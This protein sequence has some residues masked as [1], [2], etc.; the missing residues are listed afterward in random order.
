MGKILLIERHRVLRQAI[1]FSLFPEHEVEVG[2]SIS[3]SK[4]G[5]LKDYD[6]LIVDG[7]SLRQRGQLT[8]EFAR[9]IQ[10][11]KIPTIWLEDE[12]P[13][14]PPKREKLLVVKK[15]IERE[16]FLS[17]LDSLLSGQTTK[18]ERAASHVPMSGKADTPKEVTKTKQVEATQQATFE[19]IDLVDVVEEQ[20]P[21]SQGRKPPRK[22]K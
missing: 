5:S 12:E 3:A 9:A 18:R 15:P 10:S 13:S 21:P 11:C 17:S 20:P 1:T 4:V 7:A 8:P 22:S 6:L 19:F 2:E 16:A 14:H